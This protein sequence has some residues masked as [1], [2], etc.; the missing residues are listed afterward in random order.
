LALER[1]KNRNRAIGQQGG[2]PARRLA[3]FLDSKPVAAARLPWSLDATLLAM[4]IG[5]LKM[6]N[7]NI[8]AVL[9]AAMSSFLLGGL[10]YSHR[11]FGAVWCRAAGKELQQEPQMG[12]AFRVFALSFLFAL[13]SAAAFAYWLGPRPS[14]DTALFNS[15]IAGVCFV[16]AS[17][18]MNYQ[19]ANRSLVL[20][21]IDGGY[22][23]VQ[24]LVFGLILGLWH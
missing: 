11:V 16:G 1:S 24:F 14:L 7:I 12:H 15:V 3:R 9:V 18:G 21:L 8:W 23:T 17:F 20:W 4:P 5:D 13:V 19:F 22:H 2:Q 10:W 6:H